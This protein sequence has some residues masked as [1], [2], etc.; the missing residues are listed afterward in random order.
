VD[1]LVPSI[2]ALLTGSVI[3]ASVFAYLAVTGREPFM[4][5]W[6][7]AWLVLVVRLAFDLADAAYVGD[8]RVLLFLAGSAGIAYGMLLLAGTIR[9]LGKTPPRL[10]LASVGIAGAALTAAALFLG[11]SVSVAVAPAFL[12]QGV[13]L[14]ATGVAWWRARSAIGPWSRVAAATFVL[15]GVHKFDYPFVRTIPEALPLGFMVGAGLSLIVAVGVLVSYFEHARRQLERS[16]ER[17]RELFENSASVML[18]IDPVDGRIVDAN[19][20][21]EAYYGWSR[22][23]LRAMRIGD[24]NTLTEAEVA[25]EM[26]LARQ[27]RK[28][29]FEFRHRLASGEVRD[30]EVFSGPVQGEG[31]EVLYS[32]VHDVTQ[33]AEA[34]RE[35]ALYRQELEGKVAVRTA[36]LQAVNVR[37][38]GASRAKDDFLT[39]MSHEL[40]TPLNSVIGF[41][42]VLGQE[43]PGPLNEEQARQV[44]MIERAGQHLLALVNNVLDI[45]KIEAGAVHVSPTEIDIAQVASGVAQAVTPLA[46]ERGVELEL[47]LPSHASVVETDRH[48]LEQILWNLLGNAVKYTNGRTVTLS[49]GHADGSALISVSD[50][51]PG[52][53]AEQ[54]ARAFERFSRFHTAGDPGGSGLGLSISRSLAEHLGG[55]VS[56]TS[57]PGEGST[58]TLRIPVGWHL[59]G[60]EGVDASA[61]TGATAVE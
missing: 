22:D 12:I 8:S 31:R 11:V 14:I 49:I 60:R 3:L 16:E 26:A 7:V 38:E 30:V 28:S 25:A 53:D 23:Q 19:M 41:A 43:M 29:Y 40:R 4:R 58:F 17:Y 54:L 9:F 6:A 48:L 37:L 27:Q 10:L 24:I 21:A 15:W 42:H 13:A 20:S 44:A 50:T 18:V 46:A 45:A 32:I 55:T 5:I 34:E 39:R 61:T 57:R 33:R 47:D 51:G 35:L 2:V 1:W 56:A 36:E 59:H 52:M